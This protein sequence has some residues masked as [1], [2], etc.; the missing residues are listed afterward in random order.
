MSTRDAG[1]RPAPVATIGLLT[2]LALLGGLAGLAACASGAPERGAPESGAPERGA[3]ETG[4]PGAATEPA[5]GDTLRGTV[6]VVGA[7]PITQLI[8]RTEDG[9][10]DL[11]GPAADELRRVNGLVV[12]VRGHLDGSTMTVAEFRVR[13][14]EGLPAADGTL[15][16]DGNAAVL[17][18][19]DGDRL[20][21]APAPTSLRARA[22]VRV[23]IAGE[24]GGEPQAWGVIGG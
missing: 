22:G 10:I 16:I 11:Q 17:V 13:A 21:Y 8:L 9:R 1:P 5:A 6:R 18:T 7:D 15:E 20:R 14:A 4:A 24:V 23:W 12:R 3:P 19:P 2:T